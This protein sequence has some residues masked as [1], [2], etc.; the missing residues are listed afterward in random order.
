MSN[1]CSVLVARPVPSSIAD[2]TFAMDSFTPSATSFDSQ[3]VETFDDP[4]FDTEMHETRK[5]RRLSN[6]Q[7][8]V[9]PRLVCRRRSAIMAEVIGHLPVEY[10]NMKRLRLPSFFFIILGCMHLLDG[11]NFRER[12]LSCIEW[13]SGVGM[14][15]K[16]TLLIYRHIALCIYIPLLLYTSYIY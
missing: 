11:I 9:I 10:R 1:C 7:V 6:K 12:D 8:D 4:R 16:W 5:R 13:F 14:V 3:I 2:C 15:D